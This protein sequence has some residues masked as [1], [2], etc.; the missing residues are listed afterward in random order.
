[1]TLYTNNFKMGLSPKSKLIKF[2]VAVL[3]EVPPNS[4]LFS[5]FCSH[6]AFVTYLNSIFDS[7]WLRLQ[8]CI[9]CLSSRIILNPAELQDGIVQQSI[10]HD[11][12]E[13]R[14]ELQPQAVL[15]MKGN[16]STYYRVMGS[17]MNKLISSLKLQKTLVRN[18]VC[19][20]SSMIDFSSLSFQMWPGWSYKLHKGQFLNLRSV[21]QVI[22]MENVL[23]KLLIIR[24]LSLD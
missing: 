8:N 21:H 1:M 3:P 24:E 19:D 16:E 13:Y 10:E 11:G 9:Y 17:L 23:E 14:I 20:A 6:K 2:A 22:R 12:Q 18:Q 5:K 4:A 15:E 7:T